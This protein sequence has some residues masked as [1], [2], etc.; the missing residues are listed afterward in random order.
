MENLKNLQNVTGMPSFYPTVVTGKGVVLSYTDV[1]H[2]ICG[3]LVMFAR[4]LL[5]M[6]SFP[7][8]RL[9]FSRNRLVSF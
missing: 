5:C 8:R 4:E 7:N 2:I 6:C 9:F 3:P 1:L